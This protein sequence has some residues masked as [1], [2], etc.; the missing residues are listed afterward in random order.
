MKEYRMTIPAS[1]YVT[2][3][4]VDETDA[5]AQARLL[6]QYMMGWSNVAEVE[7]LTE[8]EI[9]GLNLLE[10]NGYVDA[11]DGNIGMIYQ[12]GEIPSGTGNAL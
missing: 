4:A 5:I 3:R 10:I 8:K 6:Q 11:A 9:P 7:N 12:Y 1:I 2:V